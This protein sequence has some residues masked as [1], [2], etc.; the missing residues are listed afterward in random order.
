MVKMRLNTLLGLMEEKE[1]LVAM[2]AMPLM[3]LMEVLEDLYK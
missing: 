3:V 2:E 1:V